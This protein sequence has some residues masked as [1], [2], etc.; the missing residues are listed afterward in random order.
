MVTTEADNQGVLVSSRTLMKA[1]EQRGR[2]AYAQRPRGV[3]Q[4]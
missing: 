2:S 4:Q 1:A 3:Q